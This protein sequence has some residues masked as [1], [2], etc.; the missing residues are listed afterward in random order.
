MCPAISRHGEGRSCMDGTTA[1]PLAMEPC[2]AP[3]TCTV[4]HLHDSRRVRG[5]DGLG[6]T[7]VAPLSLEKERGN[8]SAQRVGG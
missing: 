6:T 4:P 3:A 5:S 2:D 7:G 8:P 1:G